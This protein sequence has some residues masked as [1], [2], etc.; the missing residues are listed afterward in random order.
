V[1]GVSMKITNL[2]TYSVPPRWLFVK[3][4]TDE[5][6]SGWGESTL[7]GRTLTVAAAVDE[8]SD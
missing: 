4:E 7:E 6:L 5:G 1:C 8:L 3:I 2:K